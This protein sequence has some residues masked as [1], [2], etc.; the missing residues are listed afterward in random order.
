VWREQCAAQ[1]AFSKASTLFA[2]NYIQNAS[3]AH[4]LFSHR[5]QLLKYMDTEHLNN[6]CVSFKRM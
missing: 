2:S 4:F 5:A 6:R 1:V 3:T